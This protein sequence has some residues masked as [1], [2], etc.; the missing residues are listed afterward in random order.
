[1]NK[2]ILVAI[3]WPYVN[4]DIHL[5]HLA[6]YLLPADIFAR[7]QRLKGNDVLM[8]SGSDTHGTPI[9]VQADKEGVSPEE[10]VEKYHKSDVALF[11]Q[12]KLSYNLYTT[13]RTE[14]HKRVVQEL[15][16]QLLDNDYIVVDTQEQYYSSKDEQ[17][18]PD[19]YVKG[20]CPYCGAEHQRS[21]QCESCGRWIG[22]GELVAPYSVLTRA[23]VELKETE[24]YFLD[25]PKAQKE[26]EKYV[27]S[28]KDVWRNWIWKEASG[29]LKEGLEKRAITRDMDWAIELPIDEI[30][31]R[32]KSKQLKFF[33]GKR[34][35]VWFEAVIGYLSAPQEWVDLN[36]GGEDK[37]FLK[38]KGQSNDWKDW[39][40]NGDSEQF[41]FMGQDNLVFHTLMWQAE[42]MGSGV[43]YTL[44]HNVLVNKFMNYEGK[45]FSKSRNWTIDSKAMADKY[46]VD[47]VRF[48]IASNFPENKEGDF[49]WEGFVDSINNELVANLGNLVNRILKFIESS[50]EGKL[51]PDDYEL[52]EKVKNEVDSAFTEIGEHIQKGEFVAGLDRIMELTRFGNKY[53]DS[54]KVW[55][56]AKD[57]PDEAER[58]LMNMINL[59]SAIPFILAP[60]LPEGT[61]KLCMYL[62]FK[63]LNPKVGTDL[64][65]PTFRNS[66]E[67]N[68]E[69]KPVFAKLER[70]TVLA[71]KEGTSDE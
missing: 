57:H 1:M 2:K 45:K 13:T 69:V 16:L 71:E 65:Q 19:R 28:K 18:L 5:G 36:E 40:M 49:T 15:F 42:L 35:Y 23:P 7:Y 21:D 29:W 27:E 26:L 14:N 3:A 38:T 41:Y 51:S 55:K 61:G 9:T 68:H 8:V 39:W 43:D 37:I 46:G 32:P 31:K 59:I 24:H 58:I 25:F 54:S 17:F 48:Y 70:D 47:A 4:G 10:I 60:Y 67:L 22:D 33:E 20:T 66:F 34:I 63:P 30:K 6:G 11:K 56:V 12:Y 53:F 64:W 62:R 52:D 50:F 44:P